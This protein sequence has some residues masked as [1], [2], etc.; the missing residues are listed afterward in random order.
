MIAETVVLLQPIAAIPEQI[1]SMQDAEPETG[2]RET[3]TVAW[4]IRLPTIA[5]MVVKLRIAIAE[6]GTLHSR[7]IPEPAAEKTSIL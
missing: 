2:P 1:L 4:E 3:R 7:A 6:P 5:V